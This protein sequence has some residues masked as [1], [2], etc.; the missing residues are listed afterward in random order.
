M[1]LKDRIGNRSA[2]RTVV[3]QV[4][5]ARGRGVRVTLEDKSGRR[6]GPRADQGVGVAL[7]QIRE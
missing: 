6:R 5:P 4:P 2:T 7:G 1:A 3:E